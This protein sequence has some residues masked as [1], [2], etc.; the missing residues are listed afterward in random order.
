MFRAR[1]RASTRRSACVRARA[2]GHACF[3]G[4]RSVWLRTFHEGRGGLPAAISQVDEDLGR[5]GE[6]RG[7]G[8]IGWHAWS[9]PR[10]GAQ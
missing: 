1:A 6:L 8:M 4:Q 7:S 5:R 3:F 10:R 9:R 2:R